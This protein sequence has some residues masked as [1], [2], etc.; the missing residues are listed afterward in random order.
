MKGNMM[1]H[2]WSTDVATGR[3]NTLLAEVNDVIIVE[4]SKDMSLENISKNKA[5]KTDSVHLYIDILNLDEIQATT[6]FESETCHKRALKF[7]NLHYR[8]VDRI[9]NECESLKVDFHNQ[10][11]HAVILK[12]YDS[13]S[14]SDRVKKAVAIAKLIVD[15][16]Q[17]TGDEDDSI[18]NAEVRVG[19]DSGKSL[20]VNNGRRGGREPLFLGPPAN[21]AAKLASDHSNTGIYLTNIARAI[22]GLTA[23]ANPKKTPLTDEQIS[24]WTTHALI[25]TVIV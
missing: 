7:L 24:N 3:I 15:V 14:D 22:I 16:L 8:A 12:P 6:D 1:T 11:L 20:I 5:Y 18:P 4:Y 25:D 13:D 17:E 19:I 10:R 21:E 9:L 2:T 23:A